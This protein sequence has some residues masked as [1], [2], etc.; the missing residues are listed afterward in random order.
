MRL[1]QDVG[2]LIQPPTSE[3]QAGRDYPL[4]YVELLAWFPDDDAYACLE[5]L[6]SL[7][8]RPLVHGETTTGRGYRTQMD[9]PL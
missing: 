7:R 8:D 3:L 2:L 1:V 5:W 9:T 4:S 6:P